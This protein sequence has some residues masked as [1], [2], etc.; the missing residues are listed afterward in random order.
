MHMA[1]PQL[2]WLSNSDPRSLDR[3]A[4]TFGNIL[5]VTSLNAVD[6]YAL[7]KQAAASRGIAVEAVGFAVTKP[8]ADSKMTLVTLWAENPSGIDVEVD[9]GVIKRV[10]PL[11]VNVT[12]QIARMLLALPG[13][14]SAGVSH[15]PKEQSFGM[16][17]VALAAAAVFGLGFFLGRR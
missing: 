17:Q 11:P 6:E 5:V 13:V 10:L 12:E 4:Q 2:G 1:R 7:I 9:D 3:A 16:T 8:S 14:V 15:N